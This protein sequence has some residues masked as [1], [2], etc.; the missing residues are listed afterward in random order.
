MK[1]I[2]ITALALG[3]SLSLSMGAQIN[4]FNFGPGGTNIN[5]IQDSVG[6]P[7]AAGAGFVSIGVFNSLGTADINADNLSAVVADFQLFGTPGEFASAGAF[8]TAGLYNFAPSGPTEAGD[9]FVGNT[10]YTVVSD[11]AA[12]ADATEVLVFEHT[13]PFAAD[14]PLFTA[15]A[16]L[17]TT[18]PGT[19][20]VGTAGAATD[21]T[22]GDVGT[23]QLIALDGG[24]VVDPPIPEPSSVL[25]IAF[26]G[27][28]LFIR[29]RR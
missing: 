15:T 8:N 22:L 24:G 25:L 6:A 2:V 14:A 13:E 26:G 23:L 28:G 11:S 4:A 27:L 1:N 16:S 9:A 29:R 20:L 3:S 17:E 12:V 5:L 19:L 10:I 7:I 21:A 18:A